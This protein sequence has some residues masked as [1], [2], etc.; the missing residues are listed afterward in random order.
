VIIDKELDVMRKSRNLSSGYI[1]QINKSS[2]YYMEIYTHLSKII[3]KYDNWWN[4]CNPEEN[5]EAKEAIRNFCIEYRKCKPDKRYCASMSMGHSYYL[6]YLILIRQ[7]LISG[8]YQRAC[9][10]IYKLLYADFF[11]QKRVM[12]NLLA[13]LE[14]YI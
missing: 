14:E 2:G 5:L 7:A 8:L 4:D 6:F 3:K 12:V 11:L 1:E 9:S 13:L 10:E